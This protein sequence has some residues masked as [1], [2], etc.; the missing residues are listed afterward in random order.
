MKIKLYMCGGE[1][2]VSQY[3]LGL[4]YLAAY[5]KGAKITIVQDRNKL[6][7]CD[8]I[9]LYTNDHGMKEAYEILNS[10]DIPVCV[11]G[12]GTQWP[13]I[14]NIGFDYVV[15]GEGEL[16]FQSLIDGRFNPLAGQIDNI[17]DLPYPIRGKCGKSIPIISARG[18]PYDCHF[19]SSSVF[20]KKVRFHSSDYFIDE[21]EFI[22]RTEPQAKEIYIL[23]DLFVFNKKRLREIHEMWMFRDYNRRFSLRGFIRSSNFDKE[24]AIMMKE[25]GFSSVRFGAESGSDRMLKLLNKRTTVANHQ[26]VVDICNS[27]NLT[28]GASFMFKLPGETE[29]DRKLTRAFIHRNKGKMKIMGHYTFKP[30]TGTK[31]YDGRDLIK[32]DMR[33]R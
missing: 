30:F 18:C 7:N 29:E 13:K 11:G 14:D 32:A 22:R 8:L 19:C 6:N 20:W 26:R 10:T 27:I 5:S 16:P 3:P 2:P 21:V 24:I 12:Q 31:F 17:D 28:V 15:K 33:V 4:G 9:G 25:M 23:D 1:R